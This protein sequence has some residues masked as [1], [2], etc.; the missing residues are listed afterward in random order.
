ML[1]MLVSNRYVGKIQQSPDLS[2]VTTTQGILKRCAEIIYSVT[3]LLL[4]HAPDI[5][6]YFVYETWILVPRGSLVADFIG[7]I[8]KYSSFL[9]KTH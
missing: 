7:Y 6:K 5:L 9:N 1:A 8:F 2:P 4:L 3:I